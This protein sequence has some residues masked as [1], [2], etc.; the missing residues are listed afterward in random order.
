MTR[1]LSRSPKSVLST[2]IFVLLFALVAFAQNNPLENE[3]KKSF[4]KFSIIRLNDRKKLQEVKLTNRLSITTT[5][6]KFELNLVPRDLRG[7]RYK[8][9]D[10]NSGGTHEIK[11]RVE[12]LTFKGKIA[13]SSESEVRLTINDDKIEGYFD[14]KGEKYF[15]E[16]AQRY[17]NLASAE[18]VVV[19]QEKDLLKTET[20]SCHSELGEKIERGKEMV[21]ASRAEAA[22]TLRV[23]EIATDADFEYVTEV[24][25][26]NQA[27]REILSILNMVEGVYERDLNLTI[28]VVYQHTWST[29]DGF[30]QTTHAALLNSF[31]DYW[32]ANYPLSAINRDLTHLFTGKET[33]RYQGLSY[34]GVVCINPTFAY[35]FSGRINGAPGK[36]LLTAHEIGHNV[37][38]NH[39]TAAEGCSNTLMD[40][41]LSHETSVSFCSYS[42]TEI[43]NF[44][45]S[46]GSCLSQKATPQ[47][48]SPTKFDF[49]GDG[50]SDIAV[51]RPS[52]G[53][54]YFSNSGSNSFSSVAF[55][56]NGDKPV[57][58]DYDGDGK[59]DVAVYRAGTWYLIKSSNNTFETVSFGVS[60]D[61]P[62]P[63]DFDGDGRA[64]IAVFRP[65][66]GAWHR[67]LSATNAYSSVSFGGGNDV[68]LAADYDGDGKAD[69]NVFRPS[70]GVWYRINSGNGAFS[71]T[72]FGQSGDKPIIGDFDGD[73]RAD[74]AVFRL[75]S[76]TWFVLNSSNS[77]F[78][79]TSFGFSTDIPVAADYDGD[80][81][82][83]IAVYRSGIWHRINSRDNSFGTT[84]FG[85]DSDIPIPAQYLR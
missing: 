80:G 31:K 25:G 34:I 71:A 37:G 84:Y 85:A 26:A 36:F 51:F 49:D 39:V 73:R 22:Q 66:S 79:S 70:D 41:S 17:S 42:R 57:A 82:T 59:T 64:D 65:E 4:D 11:E 8:A 9:E 21:A 35:G 63:S 52:S 78:T 14:I 77:S 75:S 47:I 7:A 27:N 40:L 28:E 24:G 46:N 43:T 81:K 16:S 72:Q 76:G 45:S 23:V 38:G 53:A 19:Y 50:K 83:D 30:L 44:V 62:V 56:Q 15:I 60:S 10:T 20:F 5:E 1:F 68:P 69:I 61:I 55:G 32:N 67:L 29:P 18:D 13:G 3:L 12:I 33:A 6:K 54:W 74:L 48:K 2:P 58:A